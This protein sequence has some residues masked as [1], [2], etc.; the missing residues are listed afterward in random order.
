MRASSIAALAAA[1]LFALSLGPTPSA[2]QGG[3]ALPPAG[4]TSPRLGA[5]ETAYVQRLFADQPT[6]ATQAGIHAYD[7]R[8]PDLSADA[9]AE[10]ARTSSGAKSR[11]NK[12]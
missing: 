6:T 4:T 5:L 10:R 3:I 7:D 9:I 11:E 12:P 8:L 2:A 1:V